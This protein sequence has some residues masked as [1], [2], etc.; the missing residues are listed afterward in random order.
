MTTFVHFDPTQAG[1]ED[2]KTIDHRRE[3]GKH[4]TGTPGLPLTSSAGG[5][6]SEGPRACEWD[7]WRPIRDFYELPRQAGNS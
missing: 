5:K 2:A 3:A 7:E 6:V 4:F 1:V